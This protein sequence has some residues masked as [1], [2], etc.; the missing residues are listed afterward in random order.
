MVLEY[1]SGDLF[2]SD[3]EAIVITVNCVGVA[4]KGIAK[5]AKER[6]GHW[7]MSYH[8]WCSEDKVGIGKIHVYGRFLKNPKW[9]ISFPTK[10]HWKN[11][12]KL[13]Y[14]ECGLERLVEV[15]EERRISSISIP[16]LGCGLGR[17]NWRDV[18]RLI[19]EYLSDV[20]TVCNIYGID[21]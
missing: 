12:S 2:E 10:R 18:N 5:E 15:L 13:C 9:I 6:Y 21:I 14:I 3:V 20:E 19:K 16:K 8:N 17:L 11:P 4:G 7:N 1:V